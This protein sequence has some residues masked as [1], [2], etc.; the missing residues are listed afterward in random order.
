MRLLVSSTLNLIDDH[1]V[2]NVQWSLTDLLKWLKNSSYMVE[3]SRNFLNQQSEIIII[4]CDEFSFGSVIAK[5][6]Q[7]LNHCKRV[8][9]ISTVLVCR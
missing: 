3:F 7:F 6:T 4:S 8:Y 1:L 9:C 5:Y 2:P